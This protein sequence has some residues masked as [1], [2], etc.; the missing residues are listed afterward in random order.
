MKI[1]MLVISTIVVS[2]SASVFAHPMK[3]GDE[4]DGSWNWNQLDHAHEAAQPRAISKPITQNV[5]RGM[6][7]LEGIVKVGECYVPA[8]VEATCKNETKKVL[9]KAAYNETEIVAAVTKKVDRKILVDSAKVIEE[10]VPA[11]YENVSKKVLVEAAHTK[12]KR[13]N[14]TSVQ[15]IVDGDT[16]CLVKVPARYENKVEKIL[17]I[18]ASTKTR[19]V[20][21]VYKTYQE[22]VIVTPEITKIVK[23]YPAVYKTVK[24]C[25]E[26]EA[27]RYEW[28]SILCAQNSTTS[29]LKSF[30]KALASKGHLI[31]K[32]VD[33][34][35]DAKTT[36]AIKSYQRSK[37]L[38]VDGLVNMDTVKSLGV[39]Y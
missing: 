8:Y 36:S 30:E 28:R 32:E 25:V 7:G 5:I 14:S 2:L 4:H 18:P 27:G 3:S 29:V 33:G 1:R 17:R 35:I 39:K 9:I 21:A 26:K 6:K 24:K 31:T 19:T 38:A 15:K 34:V 10:Y 11:L 16:Y 23:T 22:T 20:A 12:W 37:G 13:G